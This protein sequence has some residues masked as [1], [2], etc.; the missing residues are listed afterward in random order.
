M[1]PDLDAQSRERAFLALGFD[2]NVRLPAIKGGEER[3]PVTGV[4]AVGVRTWLL[5]GALAG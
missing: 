1:L 4:H 3:M 5:L 2:H